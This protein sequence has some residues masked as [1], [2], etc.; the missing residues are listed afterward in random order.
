MPDKK[1]RTDRAEGSF[2]RRESDRGGLTEHH[3]A[4][5]AVREKTARLRAVRL[6]KEA[7]EKREPA[8]VQPSGAERRKKRRH[9]A[10]A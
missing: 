4:A 10:G 9:P 2:K 7:E 3:A 8:A 5:Q 6:A 1:S